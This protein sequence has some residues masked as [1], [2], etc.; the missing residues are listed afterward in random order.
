MTQP[1]DNPLSAADATAEFWDNM[2]KGG[3]RF[4]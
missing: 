2:V 3:A 4:R 1:A